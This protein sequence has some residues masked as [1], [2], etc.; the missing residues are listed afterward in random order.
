MTWKSA[1]NRLHGPLGC[2]AALN[3]KQTVILLIFLDKLGTGKKK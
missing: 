2:F 3:E 1:T